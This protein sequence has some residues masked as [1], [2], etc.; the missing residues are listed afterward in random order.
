MISVKQVLKSVGGTA[1]T[2][3]TT[4]INAIVSIAKRAYEADYADEAG[5]A[6]SADTAT[7]A[8]KATRATYATS[9]GTAYELDEDSPTR[10]EFLSSENADTAEGLITL[11]AGTQV[12]EFTSGSSGAEIDADGNAEFNK[13]VIRSMVR[14]LVFSSGFDGSGF[15]LQ[16]DDDGVTS[17][18]VDDLTVRQTM[19]IYELII[20][21]I[22][23][24]GGALVVSAASGKIASVADVM[25]VVSGGVQDYS[26]DATDSAVSCYCV[27]L[28]DEI[29]FVAGDLVRCQNFSGTNVKSYW[30]EVM[31][32]QGGYVWLRADEFDD[33]VAPEV[34]DELVLLGNTSDTSRQSAIYISASDDGVPRVDVLDGIST[35]SLDGCLRARLGYLDDIED[36]AF[37]EDD[38]PE[39]YGLYSDNAYLTGR[40]VLA[41]T[42]TSVETYV[43]ATADGI[44]SSVTGLSDTVSSL[45]ETVSGLSD[46]TD[47]LSESITSLKALV[48]SIQS[49]YGTLFEQSADLLTLL[50]YFK[51][52]DG[53]VKDMSGV[54]VT[55]GTAGIFTED[56]EGNVAKIG[57]Y[58]GGVITL[59]GEEIQLTGDVTANGN[60]SISTDGTITA[61][62]GV[63]TDA[64]VTGTIYAEAGTIGGF[65]IEEDCLTNYTSG[66]YGLYL[67]QSLIRYY[68]AEVGA[69]F[70]QNTIDASVGDYVAP[71]RVEVSRTSSD[72]YSAAN[73]GLWIDVQGLSQYNAYPISG[74]HALLIPYGD[75]CGLRVKTRSLTADAT[76]T[77]YDSFVSVYTTS[78]SITISLPVTGI[79]VGQ[80]YWIKRTGSNSLIIAT[81][82]GSSLICSGATKYLATKTFTGG[83]TIMVIWDGTY[84]QLGWS[85]TD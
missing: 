60:V 39:G 15:N 70:G 81:E 46:T 7:T 41:S 50:A 43:T 53:N 30:V 42:G 51:D 56:D 38:Q 80:V 29:E 66:K 64:T 14:T 63:F 6:E 40:F 26:E 33:G 65:T 57:T 9:S 55:S 82:D 68:D 84:W 77:K 1:V 52:S 45:S 5:H 32:V 76:L 69:Y 62:S 13:A 17:L 36:S 23:A 83:S 16:Q 78:D 85:N 35:Q 8:T 54:V 2:S 72:A 61:V 28:E 59:T 22:R 12:G 4:V 73:V 18:E 47:S 20:Q 27:A 75:I 19:R 24:V 3:A 44:S 10:E 79:E 58:S 71:V 34:G 11:S 31:N 67:S 25:G 49:D 74:N 21:R 37:G 48:E